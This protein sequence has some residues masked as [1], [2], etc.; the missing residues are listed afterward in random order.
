MHME[1]VTCYIDI[2]GMHGSTYNQVSFRCFVNMTNYDSQQIFI[3]CI[4]PQDLDSV[5]SLIHVGRFDG[6]QALKIKIKKDANIRG[7][8]VSGK[9]EC[10]EAQFSCQLYIDD[11]IPSLT[12]PGVC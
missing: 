5:P 9:G 6:R 8:Q 11:S 2:G 10:I 4:T 1:G 12:P 7:P 3:I